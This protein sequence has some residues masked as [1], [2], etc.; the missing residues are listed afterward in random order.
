[1]LKN[2]RFNNK[3]MSYSGFLIF[4]RLKRKKAALIALVK[5]ICY[6][7]FIPCLF[8]RPLVR[9]EVTSVVSYESMIIFSTDLDDEKKEQWLEKLK[10]IFIQKGGELL[11]LEPWGKRKLAYVINKFHQEGEYYLIKFKGNLEVLNEMEHFC[12]ISDEVIRSLII[13]LN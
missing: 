1:M 11:E 4:M 7:L 3:R 10:E 12:K 13:R 2:W 6:I 5:Q 8:R 9:R